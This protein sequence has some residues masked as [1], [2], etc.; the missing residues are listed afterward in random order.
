MAQSR[1]EWHQKLFSNQR[2]GDFQAASMDEMVQFFESQLY[3]SA[4]A[5]CG[6]IVP[7]ESPMVVKAAR[8]VAVARPA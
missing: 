7:K 2:F 5:F 3:V 8:A 6:P 4:L 1:Q